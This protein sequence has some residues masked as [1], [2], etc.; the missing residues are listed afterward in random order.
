MVYDP[1]F[2]RLRTPW[3]NYSSGLAFNATFDV[4]PSESGVE[5][6]HEVFGHDGDLV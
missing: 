6:V 3:I 4:A 2:L 5:S 1:F